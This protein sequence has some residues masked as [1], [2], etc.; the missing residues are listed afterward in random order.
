MCSFTWFPGLKYSSTWFRDLVDATDAR[1]H[2]HDLIHPLRSHVGVVGVSRPGIEIWVWSWFSDLLHEASMIGKCQCYERL[3]ETSWKLHTHFT[4]DATLSWEGA[5]EKC[6]GA[7]HFL[8]S[9]I[10]K[11][12]V[13]FVQSF[14]L[15]HG[16]KAHQGWR[17]WRQKTCTHDGPS[18]NIIITQI[19]KIQFPQ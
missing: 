16:Y 5:T 10:T 17:Q 7:S 4:E 6:H 19:Q 2:H 18:S 15:S 14:L 1:W 12:G 3:W 13:C 11:V 8:T 9:K